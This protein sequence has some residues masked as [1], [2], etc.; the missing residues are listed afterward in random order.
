MLVPSPTLSA[1]SPSTQVTPS[2]TPASS[3]STDSSTPVHSLQATIPCSSFSV[4]SLAFGRL[5]MHSM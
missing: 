5:A 2:C 4:S 3:K 1:L